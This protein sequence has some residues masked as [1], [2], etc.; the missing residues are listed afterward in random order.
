MIVGS[1]DVLY[2]LIIPCDQLT[3]PAGSY[4]IVLLGKRTEHRSTAVQQCCR[5]QANLYG[6]V[7]RLSQRS[8]EQWQVSRQNCWIACLG[9]RALAMAGCAQR[10]GAT[11]QVGAAWCHDAVALR[12]GRQEARHLL[13][14][15]ALVRN[16]C[17]WTWGKH[18]CKGRWISGCIS[19][20]QTARL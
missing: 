13:S 6:G 3:P 4:V 17:L 7:S 2:P 1:A 8:F 18:G 12:A 16:T 5:Q 20:M 9:T 19:T 10:A 11:W 15:G 14:A